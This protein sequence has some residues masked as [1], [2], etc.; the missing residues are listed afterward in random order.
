MVADGSD[1][2]NEDEAAVMDRFLCD[3][4]EYCWEEGEAKHFLADALS[5]VSHFL[6]HFKGKLGQAWAC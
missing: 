3:W 1:L 4:G 5:S 2:P 6:P